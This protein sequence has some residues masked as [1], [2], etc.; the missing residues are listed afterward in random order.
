MGDEPRTAE[1][2]DGQNE[3]RKGRRSA[4]M[5]IGAGQRTVDIARIAE[6]IVTEHRLNDELQHEIEAARDQH[7]GHGPARLARR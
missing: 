3:T 4:R 1:H 6:E 7:R 5:G 2:H